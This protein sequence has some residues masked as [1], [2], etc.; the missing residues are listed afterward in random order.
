M[1]LSGED[2]TTLR[3]GLT[4]YLREFAAHRAGDGGAS[5]P[6]EEWVAIKSR[7]GNCSGGLRQ[8]P[9]LLARTSS[10]AR[11]PSGPTASRSRWTDQK[12][13]YAGPAL[14]DTS[15]W[16][17]ARRGAGPESRRTSGRY[18]LASCCQ[19]P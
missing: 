1:Q 14:G 15:G 4:A 7:L 12:R 17:G 9:G 3:I 10:T 16:Q 18:R 6:E 2:I 8:R 5:H 11:T 19:G 13:R